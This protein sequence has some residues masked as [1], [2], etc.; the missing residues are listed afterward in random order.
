MIYPNITASAA[1]NI[2]LLRRFMTN[3]L[4]IIGSLCDIDIEEFSSFENITRK[5]LTTTLLL[6]VKTIFILH[7]K[8]TDLLY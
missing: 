3:I 7:R 1:F 2:F 4:I 6:I 5:E 8:Y